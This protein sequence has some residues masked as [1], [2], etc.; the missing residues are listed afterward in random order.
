MS[1]WIGSQPRY[2][3]AMWI[4][5]TA[6]LYAKPAAS[7]MGSPVHQASRDPGKGRSDDGDVRIR[8]GHVHLFYLI[9]FF[10]F[11]SLMNAKSIYPKIPDTELQENL[12]AILNN[13][14]A[15]QQCV[16]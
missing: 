13:F 8:V 6:H 1:T 14:G 3:V 7:D 10:L 9:M 4:P 5:D 2:D 15:V 16:V 11:I 12:Y